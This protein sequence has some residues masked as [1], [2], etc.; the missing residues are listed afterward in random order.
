MNWLATAPRGA[1]RVQRPGQP[2]GGHALR[3]APVGVQPV[4]GEVEIPPTRPHHL[5]SFIGGVDRT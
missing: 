2:D 1:V 5:D 4:G 3:M